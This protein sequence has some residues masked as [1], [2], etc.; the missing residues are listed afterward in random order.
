MV[1]AY[2]NTQKNYQKHP[3]A[4]SFFAALNIAAKL[5]ARLDRA[6]VQIRAAFVVS[7]TAA[8]A[9]PMTQLLRGGRGGGEVKLKLLLSMMWVAAREPYDVTHPSRVWA[10]LLGLEDPEKKGAARISAA[11]RRLVEGGYLTAEAR[12]GR[13]SRL[14]LRDETGRGTDYVHPGRYWDPQASESDLP[15]RKDKQYYFQLPTE[16][17]TKGWITVLSGPAVAMFLALLEQTRGHRFEG[18]WFSQS[19]ADRRYGLTEVTRRK[20]LQELTDTGLIETVRERIGI[21]TFD[22]IRYR[23][24]Y[25]VKLEHLANQPLTVLESAQ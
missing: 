4:A 7:T 11:I 18:I 5:D 2:S 19:V 1:M 21:G 22:T 3:T 10:E 16:F 23:N 15:K 20:G 14:I 24:T 8:V 6:A 17:W 13:P 25:N 12:P 9:P